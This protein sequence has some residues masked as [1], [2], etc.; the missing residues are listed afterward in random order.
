MSNPDWAVRPAYGPPLATAK[1][2]ATPE[3][4]QVGELLGFEPAGE[5]E[6]L[7][8]HIEKRGLTTQQAAKQLARG[9]GVR[10]R[11]VGWAGLKDKYAVTR[12][13]LSL[14]WPIK[15]EL[16]QWAGDDDALQV[17]EMARHNRKLRAGSHSANQFVID[18]ELDE[19][20]GDDALQARVAEVLAGGI[21]NGF[22]P[23]RFG[24]DGDNVAQFMAAPVD[25][26]CPGILISAA[27]SLVFN[28]VLDARIA[29][30]TWRS[31][32]AGDWMMLD[33]S[34]SGFVAAEL[35]A[36]IAKRLAE[37]DLHPTGPMPGTGE[38]LASDA[39]ARLEQEIC[40]QHQAVVQRLQARDV[41]AD[42]RALR[43]RAADLHAELLGSKTARL[44]FTLP[45]GSFATTLVD[46]LFDISPI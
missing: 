20:V 38:T 39:A 33:G 6:H 22:G 15:R 9:F 28:S 45:P 21:P 1:L 19:P 37:L 44:R 27:R 35:D 8:V 26:R 13:W 36:E 31:G 18:C 16:P 32:L 2:R 30:G 24:R 29:D 3:S 40:S 41:A 25:A 5:G 23:Q 46:Q 17:L 7:L 12:Q 43:M 4:F 34:H 14:P 11:N 42:R 10:V